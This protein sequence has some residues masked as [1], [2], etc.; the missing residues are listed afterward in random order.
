AAIKTAA[1]NGNLDAVK[2]LLEE[3]AA[4]EDEAKLP[5]SQAMK[6]AASDY[7]SAINRAR[8]AMADGYERAVSEYTKLL[9]IES[10]DAVNKEMLAF[11]VQQGE[12]NPAPAKKAKPPFEYTFHWWKEGEPPVKMIHKDEGFCYLT[13]VSGGFVGGG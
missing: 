1:E 3:E 2:A 4:F 7:Q 8:K 5:T 13:S 6:K 10:A 12:P 11:K 9:D